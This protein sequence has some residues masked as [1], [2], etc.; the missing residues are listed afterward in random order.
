MS[1]VYFLLT[2]DTEEDNAWNLDF[3][4]HSEQTVHNI[5][6]LPRFQDFC[7]ALGIRP[8]YLVDYP[9]AVDTEAARVLRDLASGTDC[10]VGAHLH[11]WCNPPYRETPGVVNSFFHR[12]PQALQL[13]KMQ[14]LTQAIEANLGVRPISY[15]AGRYGFDATTIP[16]L[17]QLGYRVD[18][19]VVPYRRAKHPGEPSFPITTLYPYPLHRDD[20]CASGDS[21]ILEVPIT[22]GFTRRVPKWLKKIYPDL[23][24]VGIRRVLRSTLGLDLVWL[25]PSYASVDAMAR[26]AD[27]V[28]QSGVPILNMMFHS[29]ELMPG[30][31]PYNRTK[32]DVQRFLDRIR[33][34]LVILKNAHTLHCIT[35]GETYPIFYKSPLH[36]GNPPA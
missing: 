15:R 9:V 33:Q 6:W 27:N 30:A 36:V 12:L 1:R 20:V 25:R 26:L 7:E 14:V 31:S 8:T 13:E 5:Q 3:K 10:E 29:S 11:P 18:S 4:P 32:D 28:L 21:S 23:P 16:V 24:N 34:F 17:E 2:I 19:S 22:V 35:L